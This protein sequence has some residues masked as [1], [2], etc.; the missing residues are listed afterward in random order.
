MWCYVKKPDLFDLVS[1][2][3]LGGDAELTA[4]QHDQDVDIFTDRSPAPLQISSLEEAS[5]CSVHCGG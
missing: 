4:D 5:K 3:Q 2:S 1:Q